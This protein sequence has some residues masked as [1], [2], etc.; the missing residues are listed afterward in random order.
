MRLRR[1]ALQF[2]FILLLAELAPAAVTI[3]NVTAS[4]CGVAGLRVA[5]GVAVLS[6]AVLNGNGTGILLESAGTLTI[7]GVQVTSSAGNGI[8]A[9][10]ALSASSSQ[11]S[12]SEGDGIVIDSAAGVNLTLLLIDN[13]GKAGVRVLRADNAGLVFEAFGS[14]VHDNGGDGIILGDEVAQTG[15]VVARIERVQIFSNAVG[16]RAQQ[17]NETTESTTTTLFGNLIF[18]NRDSGLHMR[19]SFLKRRVVGAT[20]FLNIQSNKVFHNGF[21][22]IGCTGPQS[23]PQ[24]AFVG[25]VS[26]TPEQAVI[27][28]AS[29]QND[30]EVA[31]AAGHPCYWTTGANCIPV[32]D[33]R[34]AVDC[35]DITANPNQIHSYNTNTDPTGSSELSVGLYA[36]GGANVWA[37]NNSWRTGDEAQNVDQDAS[38]FVDA[39]TICPAG[40]IFLACSSQ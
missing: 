13:N 34:G 39:D 16:I 15:K 1:A 9:R 10:G 26:V 25:P 21:A 22:A 11:I 6:G 40:G 28:S 2:G 18:D 12:G 14:Q 19:S 3:S 8:E 7:D 27:C 30:C 20:I 37:D 5:E 4:G 35:E 38:S 31:G 17:K 23:A 29:I 24:I 32:W 33:M 36:S